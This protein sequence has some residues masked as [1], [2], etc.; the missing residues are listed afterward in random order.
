[1]L[2]V[3]VQT[4]GRGEALVADVTDVRLFPRVSSHVTLQ[5]TWT[6][7]GFATNATRQHC[8][9]A[10]ARSWPT[11]SPRVTECVTDMDL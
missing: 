11:T 4:R 2:P 1:M 5:Q 10:T 8:L 7:E 6:I 9:P 3:S